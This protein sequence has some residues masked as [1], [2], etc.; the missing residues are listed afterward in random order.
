MALYVKCASR[1]SACE[2]ISHDLASIAMR[3]H[4]N[5]RVYETH[6]WVTRQNTRLLRCPCN[7]RLSL[8]RW[9]V[10]GG[11]SSAVEHLWSL[12]VL[13]IQDERMFIQPSDN[14]QAA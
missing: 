2:S 1:R 6:L 8:F 5:G 7:K 3:S 10:N 9:N 11:L 12:Q 4:S 14:L 13:S